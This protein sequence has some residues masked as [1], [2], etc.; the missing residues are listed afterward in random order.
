MSNPPIA[1]VI[2][3]SEATGGAGIQVDL[4]TFQ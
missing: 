3:G 2:A 4:K 1:F